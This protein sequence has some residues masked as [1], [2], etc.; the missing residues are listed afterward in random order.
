MFLIKD[1]KQVDIQMPILGQEKYLKSKSSEYGWFESNKLYISYYIDTTLNFKRM[2]F[3]TGVISYSDVSKESENIFLN[4]LINFIK[5]EDICDF[6]YKA[7]GNVVFRNCPK[8]ADCIGWGTYQVFLPK[9]K[10]ELFNSFS[11]KSRNIIRKAI[12]E[13]VEVTLADNVNEV[14][15]NIKEMF[16]RQNSFH[17]PSYEYLDYLFHNLPKNALLLVSKQDCIVQGSLVLV[18]DCNIAYAMYAGS[19]RTPKTG[20]LDLLHFEAMNLMLEKGVKKYDFVGTRLNI[21]KDSKQAGIDRFK[22][23]FN[24]RLVEGYAFKVVLHPYKH[25]VYNLLVKIYFFMKGY[26]YVEFIE[27]IKNDIEKERGKAS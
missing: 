9:N 16:E 10:D 2:V 20:S 23:K 7:Q 13:G 15:I 24:P 14:Y 1:E 3:T 5:Q 12:K 4:K 21:I 11:G 17:T 8:E 26:K 27:Q 18:Y 6:I 25:F 19:I 22:R